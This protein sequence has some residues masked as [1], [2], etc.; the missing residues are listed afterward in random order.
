MQAR[1]APVHRSMPAV[2]TYSAGAPT[3]PTPGA[4]AAPAG[5]GVTATDRL[6]AAF[7]ALRLSAGPGDAPQ[8]Q[9]A[10][11]GAAAPALSA[12]TVESH[13]DVAHNRAFWKHLDRSAH[14]PFDGSPPNRELARQRLESQA[15]LVAVSQFA[16]NRRRITAWVNAT[17]RDSVAALNALR[18]GRR[19]RL[20][21]TFDETTGVK[22]TRAEGTKRFHERPCDTVVVIVSREPTGHLLI[23]AYPDVRNRSNP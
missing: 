19:Q 4:Q 12:Q 15:E 21:K 17:L 23:T 9:A 1:N 16:G 10:G 7:L 11:A 22:V 5:N 2:S 6:G 3:M 18:P 13:F 20:A 8:V 14:F